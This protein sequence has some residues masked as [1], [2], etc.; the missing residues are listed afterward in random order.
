VGLASSSLLPSLSPT[1]SLFGTRGERGCVLQGTK[2]PR[3]RCCSSDGRMVVLAPGR[4]DL[5]YPPSY[6]VVRSGYTHL[7]PAHNCDHF[8]FPA[9]A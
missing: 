2:C 9:P 8:L 7:G 3:V 6:G 5:L 1:R 4:D